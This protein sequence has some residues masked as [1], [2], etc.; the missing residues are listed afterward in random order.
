MNLAI[1]KKLLTV[2]TTVLAVASCGSN[3]PK[4]FND[5]KF[6]AIKTNPEELDYAKYTCKALAETEGRRIR[7]SVAAATPDV[8]GGGFAGGFANGLQGAFEGFDAKRDYFKVCM[9]KAGYRIE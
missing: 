8:K 1:L 9:A 2:A 3:T 6:I 4:K 5:I 7:R